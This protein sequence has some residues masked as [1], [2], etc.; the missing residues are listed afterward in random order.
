MFQLGRENK[1]EGN[2]WYW[3]Q[4][5]PDDIELIDSSTH[6]FYFSLGGEG[7]DVSMFY[8]SSGPHLHPLFWPLR[9]RK[10]D[11]HRMLQKIFEMLKAVF[12]NIERSVSK[13]C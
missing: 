4:K 9:L 3:H 8:T 5:Q 2:N 12:Q 7:G 11:I 10:S 6:L 13:Y 1:I